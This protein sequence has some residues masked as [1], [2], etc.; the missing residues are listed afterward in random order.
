MIEN[1]L[2]IMEALRSILE[3]GA[4]VGIDAAVYDC[5]CSRIRKTRDSLERPIK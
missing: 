5:L 2:V 1:E 4:L 3:K